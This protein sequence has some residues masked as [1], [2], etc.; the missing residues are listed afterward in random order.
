MKSCL[1]DANQR[2][3]RLKQQGYEPMIE[4]PKVT[5][6]EPA[7][8]L[9]LRPTCSSNKKAPPAPLPPKPPKVA[10]GE[11]VVSVEVTGTPMDVVYEFGIEE[12]ITCSLNDPYEKNVVETIL[13]ISYTLASIRFLYVTPLQV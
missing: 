10:P 3:E 4:S 9:P 6:Q 12:M 2:M 8:A 5:I 1:K 7:P 13:D 11:T